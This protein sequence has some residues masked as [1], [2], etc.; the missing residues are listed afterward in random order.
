MI[1]GGCL[2][3]GLWYR[4]QFV[5]RVLALR[6]LE[7]ILEML[8][9][10]IRYGKATLPESCGQL[11]A[12][13]PGPFD[14]CLRRIQFE[15]GGG[16]PFQEVFC[17]RMETAMKEL[18]LKREDRELFLQAF[19]GQGF[20]DGA[21]QLKRLEQGLSQLS[22]RIAALEREQREKCRMAVGLGAM[23]GLLLL[24]ILL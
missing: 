23:S 3:L 9:S 1:V 2:G 11:A 7:S 13:L 21:M 22:G 12:R 14:Q 20:Q 16:I 6:T 17:T 19:Q 15:A 10:E 18:P 5:G 8:M 4:E 24:I